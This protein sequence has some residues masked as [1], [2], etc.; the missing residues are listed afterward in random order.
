MKLLT[1]GTA[2]LVAAAG[3][4]PLQAQQSGTIRGLVTDE[5]S[6][7]PLRGV[8]VRF[9]KQDGRVP[10]RWP[11]RPHRCARRLGFPQGSDDRLRSDRPSSHGVGRRNRRDGRRARAPGGNL[12]ELVVVGYGEQR[13][14]NVTGALTNVTS[15]E[16]NKGRVVTPTELIQNKVAGVQ[17]VESTEPGGKTSIRIRGGTS[18]TASNE[19]LYVV[20][21]QPLGTDAGGG[22]S[23]G[24]DPLNF[25][26]PDDIASM[27][28][29]RDAGAAAIYG[30]NAANG[31]ILITTK[32]GQ[33]GQPMKLEYTGSLSASTIT[34]T[35]SM[36]SAAQFRTAVEE[37]RAGEPR[38]AAE[39]EHRLVWRHRPDRFRSGAQ[40][41][42][43]GRRR[44]ERLS[45]VVQLPGPAGPHSGE[46]R[47]ADGAGCQLQSAARRRPAQSALQREGFTVRRPLHAAR[48]ALQRHAVRPDPADH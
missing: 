34:R 19:P 2:L 12:A 44:V 30:T 28:V 3:F 37:L 11:L 33:S 5:A 25:I 39:R 48:R 20:D 18:T 23:S 17:V 40:R 13:Q 32:R 9:G 41:G 4:A 10:G 29:L 15:Q 24:R 26:N 22:V 47:P 45:R 42:V 31:V 1:F 46:Q 35:P 21:G 16:F 38:S 43:V 14:G 36:L 27:T 6:Q 8:V 7:A